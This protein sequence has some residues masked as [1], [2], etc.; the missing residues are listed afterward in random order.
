MKGVEIFL[1][2][3]LGVFILWLLLKKPCSSE[4]YKNDLSD[5]SGIWDI[6]KYSGADFKNYPVGSVTISDSGGDTFDIVL[7]DGRKKTVTISPKRSTTM[8]MGWVGPVGQYTP[9]TM[10]FAFDPQRPGLFGGGMMKDDSAH[11]GAEYILLPRENVTVKLDN[12][13]FMCPNISYQCSSVA[14]CTKWLT[15]VRP[16]KPGDGNIFPDTYECCLTCASPSTCPFGYDPVAKKCFD[17]VPHSHY[18]RD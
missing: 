3:A 5:L 14:N 9:Q 13:G 4:S 11:G 15:M 18:G 16:G 1:C 8:V 17:M 12:P 6:Y 10:E 7:F 2:V